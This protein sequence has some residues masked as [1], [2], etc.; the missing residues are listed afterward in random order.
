[1]LRGNPTTQ[2]ISGYGL[3]SRLDICSGGPRCEIAS[4][5]NKRSRPCAL[6]GKADRAITNCC[7]TTRGVQSGH[8]A[9]FVGATLLSR[10][11]VRSGDSCWCRR[12]PDG[13]FRLGGGR[14]RTLG[15][16]ALK[17]VLSVEGC[18]DSSSLSFTLATPI[19][20]ARLPCVAFCALLLPAPGALVLLFFPR[21][22]LASSSFFLFW[23]S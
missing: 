9:I 15:N 1:M 16:N 6:D 22:L 3:Q 14:R 10:F 18:R 19:R 13:L 21:M 11:R 7:L 2:D 17:S 5:N 4:D 12:R 8:Q 20:L 23:R